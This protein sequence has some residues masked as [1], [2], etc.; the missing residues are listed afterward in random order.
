MFFSYKDVTFVVVIDFFL[1][2]E[3]LKVALFQTDIAWENP[4]ENRERLAYQLSRLSTDTDMVFLPEMFTSGFSP[5]AEKIA[6]TMQGETIEWLKKQ[7]KQYNVAIGGSLVI[8]QEQNYFN[9]LVIAL[10]EGNFVCYDKRHLFTSS[11][12]KNVYK[13]GEN[14]YFL[15]YKGWKLALFICYDLR[16]PV[17]VR[18][19]E[20]YDAAVFVANFPYQR[21]S[22]WDTLLRSRAIENMCY[23]IG[24][25]RVGVDKNPAVYNG[26]SAVYN[27]YGEC[28]SGQISCDETIIYA[29]LNTKTLH[30]HRSEFPALNDV[31]NFYLKN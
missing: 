17:W 26:H 9:R 20:R 4:K 24:V 10:P 8:G 13:C 30:K 22:A 7:A 23:T 3:F 29:I 15:T 2:K 19:T 14:Q 28:V 31:D 5:N 21:I 25:N 16:F 12:E 1:M 27:S 11:H 18:N 6:E